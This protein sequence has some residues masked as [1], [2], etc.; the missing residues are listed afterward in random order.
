MAKGV[1][2][3]RQVCDR[4]GQ[5]GFRTGGMLADTIMSRTPQTAVRHIYTYRNTGTGRTLFICAFCVRELE[6]G[7]EERA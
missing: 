6:Y 3:R 7:R 5:A 2:S 1:R 4:C